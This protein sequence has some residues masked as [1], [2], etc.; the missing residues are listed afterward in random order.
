M[1]RGP[2]FAGI[3]CSISSDCV[4]FESSLVTGRR[5]RPFE[6][7][8][9]LSAVFHCL[10]LPRPFRN[11][12]RQKPLNNSGPCRFIAPKFENLASEFPA[13]VFVKVDVDVLQ[14]TAAQWG[15][16]AMPTIGYFI[17][18]NKVD[19]VVGA[20]WGKIYGTVKARYVVPAPPKKKVGPVTESRE[21]L[22]A[23]SVKELKGMM[24]ERDISYAGLFE[25]GELVG[26]LLEGK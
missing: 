1:C 24:D 6:S 18:G 12:I 20:D 22:M 10:W 2:D 16:T 14:R 11:K 19:T 5:S 13:A 17:G 3:L 4:V 23:R 25:K 21:Q 15:I 8:L 26:R 7:P 9:T